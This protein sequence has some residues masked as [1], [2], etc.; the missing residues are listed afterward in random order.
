[1]TI[2]R[3]DCFSVAAVPLHP[4]IPSGPRIRPSRGLAIV[5]FEVFVDRPLQALFADELHP[6]ANFAFE[7][8]NEPQMCSRDD[9]SS[10]NTAA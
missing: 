6:V 4:Q 3:T 1:M 2:L 5:V 9:C 10:E 8:T 7:Q